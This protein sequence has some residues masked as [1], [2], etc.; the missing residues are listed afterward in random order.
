LD[1][2]CFLLRPLIKSFKMI[3]GTLLIVDE[4]KGILN[5]LEMIMQ[6]EFEKVITITDPNRINEILRKNDVDVVMLDMVTRD[7]SG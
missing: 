6:N 3:K 4:N 1:T 7:F 2:F 5:A